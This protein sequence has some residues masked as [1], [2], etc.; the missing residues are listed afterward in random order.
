MYELANQIRIKELPVFNTPSC[1]KMMEDHLN[2]AYQCGVDVGELAINIFIYEADDL[3]YLVEYI[4]MLC[5][6][7]KIFRDILDNELYILR[8]QGYVD[9]K[10]YSYINFHNLF[11]EIN[12]KLNAL[13][14]DQ[15][16]F[17]EFGIYHSEISLETSIAMYEV[18]NDNIIISLNKFVDINVLKFIFNKHNVKYLHDIYESIFN[19]LENVFLMY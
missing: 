3:I 7:T 17:D 4:K 1:V 13:L 2:L 12:N 5:N 6:L 18:F 16:L 9:N 11:V 15:F 14:S 10:I 19:Q 8:A